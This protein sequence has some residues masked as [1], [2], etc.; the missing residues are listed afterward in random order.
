MSI[1][2]DPLVFILENMENDEVAESEVRLD[3]AI[4]TRVIRAKLKLYDKFPDFGYT[5]NQM[6]MSTDT[7]VTK[8]MAI[9]QS[10]NIYL[11]PEF[12][13]KLSENQL[14]GVFC[15][16]AYHMIWGT[17]FR[18]GN[19]NH[20]LWNVATDCK[21]NLY[22]LQDGLELP[23]EAYIPTLDGD[24]EIY[25]KKYNIATMSAEEL[26]SRL[27]I[28]TNGNTKKPNDPKPP[29]GPGGDPPPPGDG[30]GGDPP[31]PGGGKGGEPPPE[32]PNGPTGPG[33]GKGKPTDKKPEG[34]QPAGP[35]GDTEDDEGK[36]KGKGQGKGDDG[37]LKPEKELDKHIYEP[38]KNKGDMEKAT[39]DHWNEVA[40]G[41]QREA[42]NRG[43]GSTSFEKGYNERR[44]VLDW[45]Q[46]LQ[47]YIKDSKT[48]VTDYN[49]N[50]NRG[51]AIKSWL[52]KRKVIE[53]VDVVVAIDISGSISQT[54]YNM[55]VSEVLK[56]F[57]TVGKVTGVVLFWGSIVH[58]PMKI[59]DSTHDA[60]K[61]HK[62][63]YN[64]GTIIGVVKDYIVRENLK[65]KLVIYFTDGAV[66]TV[67]RDL[68]INK[69]YLGCPNLFVLLPGYNNESLKSIP[70][71]RVIKITVDS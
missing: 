35:G 43:S 23:E 57:K 16:E 25:G 61:N 47:K 30:K 15:H 18:K 49:A 52:G 32:P 21:I 68:T 55:F 40:A 36:D 44:A 59:K 60:I 65:P 69:F 24:I 37:Q 1:Y 28:D 46:I 41:A 33:Q 5:L 8:T 26:Y 66:G 31:P 7:K 4:K 3:P 13:N 29:T 71:S 14:M 53:E 58:D 38:G 63:H 56:I 54:D 42:S 27:Y 10:G 9:D 51:R 67:G 11:N 39:Q 2:K 6:Y 64:D 45:K 19:K 22:L 48:T 70:R 34:K 12:V 17:L 20:H 62:F 50:S